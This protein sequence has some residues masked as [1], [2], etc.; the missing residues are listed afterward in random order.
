MSN[1]VHQRPPEYTGGQR[2][3]P[4]TL[5]VA[6]VLLRASSSLP[7]SDCR[8]RASLC[9]IGQAIRFLGLHWRTHN[10]PTLSIIAWLFVSNIILGVNA[11]IWRQ[12]IEVAA[13][14]CYEMIGSTMALPACYLYLCIHLERIAAMREVCTTVEQK[15]R[16]H[17]FDLALCWGPPTISMALH[18]LGHR[19]NT[20]TPGS[21]RGSPSRATSPLRCSP[22]PC[23]PVALPVHHGHGAH[24][25]VLGHR[26]HI[27]FTVSPELQPCVSWADVHSGISRG[28][29]F[30]RLCIPQA[31]WDWTYFFWMVPIST[32]FF[33]SFVAFG[34]GAVE[35]RRPC[36]AALRRVV[37]IPEKKK[38]TPALA[39]SVAHFADPS[40]TDFKDIPLLP[41]S[42][43]THTDTDT[44]TET[45][46]PAYSPHG[47]SFDTLSMHQVPFL[48]SSHSDDAQSHSDTLFPPM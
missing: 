36:G 18:V 19:A 31:E 4:V 13:L 33:F 39:G 43:V 8:F 41:S 24:A 5:P 2:R 48:S 3:P 29:V 6:R 17:I 21:A 14:A 35:E 15:T 9:Q 25:D 23:S 20:S 7:H 38:K 34:Q 26:A 47:Y 40:A 32:L 16:L 1:N 11:I 27:W 45:D 42:F 44:A 37:R 10:V 22:T 46:I 30:P 12:T 28:G